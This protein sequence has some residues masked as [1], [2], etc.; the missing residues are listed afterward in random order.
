MTNLLKS[1]TNN[2][3]LIINKVKILLPLNKKK[4]DKN[5]MK[6]IF[7]MI[8]VVFLSLYGEYFSAIFKIYRN[9]KMNVDLLVF[10]RIFFSV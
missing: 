3:L 10:Y 7:L 2:T 4:I 6:Y 9:T 8:K 1:I 5:S